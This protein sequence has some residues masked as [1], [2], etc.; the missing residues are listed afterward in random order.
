MCAKAEDN[1]AGEVANVYAGNEKLMKDI[2]ISSVPTLENTVVYIAV[3]GN[4][5]GYITFADKIKPDAAEAVKKLKQLGVKK[6]VMLTGDKEQTARN[7][8]AGNRHRRSARRA[9]ATGQSKRNGK[10]SC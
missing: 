7:V 3:N 1:A 5:A 6:T 2:G 8:A 9:S 4:F 10:N